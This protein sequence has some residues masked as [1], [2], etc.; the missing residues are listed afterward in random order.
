MAIFTKLK[1]KDIKNIFLNYDLSP[2]EE[3]IP[4]HQGIQNTNYYTITKNSKFILTIFEDKNKDVYH[5]PNKFYLRQT[6]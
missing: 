1:K 2:L 3:Y 4:I 6:Y 5:L